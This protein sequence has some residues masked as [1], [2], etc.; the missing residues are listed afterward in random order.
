VAQILLNGSGMNASPRPDEHNGRDDGTVR[1]ADIRLACVLGEGATHILAA[2]YGFDIG[3][4][5]PLLPNGHPI[6]GRQ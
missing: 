6:Q 5:R 3:I 4:K 2:G 1:R